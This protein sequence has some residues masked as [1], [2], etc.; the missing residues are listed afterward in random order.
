VEVLDGRLEDRLPA[1]RDGN[2][3]VTVRE[4]DLVIVINMETA[5]VEW[6]LQDGWGA[7]HQATVLENGNLMI[8]DNKGNEGSSRI[9]EF[10]PVTHEHVW[11]YKGDEP[12]DFR[13]PECGSNHRLQNGNTLIVETDRGAAF[14]VT[15]DGTIVW[16]YINPAQAG[17]ELQYIASL[18]E[19]ERLPLD[20][21]SEWTRWGPRAGN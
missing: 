14:E 6:A 9:I 12:E 4:L 21:G 16:K 1:F 8:F 17:P 13:S 2:V 20:F 5:L 7:P 11:V 18:F 15:P 10:D 3:L 19:V